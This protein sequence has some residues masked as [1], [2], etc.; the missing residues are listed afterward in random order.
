V[1]KYVPNITLEV[2]ENRAKKAKDENNDN[3]SDYFNK[4][5]Q[6]IK[7]K[8]NKELFSNS[9]LMSDLLSTAFYIILKLLII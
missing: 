3:L 5:A 1:K 9:N 7:E 2:F 8:S 4:F 6:Q